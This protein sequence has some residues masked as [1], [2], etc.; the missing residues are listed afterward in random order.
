ML[1]GCSGSLR[2]VATPL[3]TEF[4]PTAVA[5]TLQA[6]GL[7]Q[8]SPS[9]TPLRRLTAA[10]APPTAPTAMDTV[11]PTATA[12]PTFTPTVTPTLED[13]P[14]PSPTATAVPLT[15]PPSATATFLPEIPQGRVQIYQLGELSRVVSPLKIVAWLYSEVGRVV[16][17]ELYGEDGRLLGRELKV[18][19][20]IPWHVGSVNT[21]MDFEIRAEAELG[22][23]VISVEDSYG[24][25]IDVNSV[26]LILLKD[27]VNDL[28]PASALWQT[29]YIQEPLPQTFIQGGT[30]LVTGLARPNADRPLRAELIDRSGN[31]LGQRLAGVDIRI[32]GGYGAFAADIPYSVSEVTPALLVVYEDGGVLSAIAHLAS[33]EVV[34]SP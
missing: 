14:T 34:L 33:V 4:M 3:P 20:T 30:A 1:T 27:G 31:V 12:S 8:V 5:L 32:P 6:S 2:A 7:G 16:R 29:I 28:H 22:R 24:R 15:P 25:L 19:H 11:T 17:V 9:P 13:T 18:F 21:E 23:L 26:N 10:T